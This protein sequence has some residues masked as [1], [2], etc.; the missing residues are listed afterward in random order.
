MFIVSINSVCYQLLRSLRSSNAQR[1]I[2]ISSLR[3]CLRAGPVALTDQTNL[4]TL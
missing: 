2:N 1:S 4:R 3:D